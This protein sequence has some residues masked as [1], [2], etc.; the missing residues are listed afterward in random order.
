MHLGRTDYG[1]NLK[2]TERGEDTP[3]PQTPMTGG[4]SAAS[5]TPRRLPARLQKADPN[6]ESSN[7]W[8][9][10]AWLCSNLDGDGF[11]QSHS[12]MYRVW[13]MCVRDESRIS[14]A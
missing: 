14:S 8:T 13:R 10:P 1:A 5:G 6:F 3:N 4:A 7:C 11:L 12:E 2:Y 9:S